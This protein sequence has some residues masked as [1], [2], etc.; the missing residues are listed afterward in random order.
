VSVEPSGGAGESR[1]VV[2]LV[3]EADATTGALREALAAEAAKRPGLL[4]VDMSR[5]TFIDSSA[6][7]VV[8]KLH[9]DLRGTE[10]VLALIS[11]SAAVMR[12]LELLG[13]DQVIPIYASADEA[14]N[15]PRGF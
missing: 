10:S 4:L 8:L 13:A 15:V 14:V 11:P 9:R 1:T 3:G 12:V 7:S 5:L 2:R 6:I